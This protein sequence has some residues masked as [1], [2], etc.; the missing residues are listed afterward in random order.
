MRQGEDLAT[1]AHRFRTTEAALRELREE[2]AIKSAVFLAEHP[3][4]LTYDLPME[5]IG[6]ALK[7]KYRGQCQRWFAMRFVGDDSEIDIGSRRGVKAEFDRWAWRQPDE[8]A[9]LVVPF[10]RKVYEAVISDFAQFWRV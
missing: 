8:L 9:E 5:L 2:T 7:G 1:V 4:W 10:K 3:Q 6:I